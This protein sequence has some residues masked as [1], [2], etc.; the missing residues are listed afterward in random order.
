MTSQKTALVIGA[1]GIIGNHI[2]RELLTQGYEV[3]A[4]SRGVTSSQNL[5][6]LEVKSVQ[7]DLNDADSLKKAFQGIDYVFQAGAYY[8]R[9][10]FHKNL[11]DH[12]ALAQVENLIQ[13]LKESD[14]QKLVYTSSLTTIGQV[15][16][17][18]LADETHS[19][20]LTS[21]DPHPYFSL[22]HLCEERLRKAV[23]EEGVPIVIVN[24]TGVFG[25]YE[26]KPKSLCLVPQL[27]ERSLPAYVD[28][29][30]NVVSASD[31]AKGQILAAVQGREGERYILGSENTMVATVIHE[32]CAAAGVKP[33]FLKLPVKLAL[34]PSI[35]S[36]V[37][38]Y[39]TGT[40]PVM[41]SLGLRFVQYGQHFSIEKAKKEL[42]FQPTEMKP[43]YAEAIAWFRQI[44][45]C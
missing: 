19:Y 22:K 2:V 6:N 35:M 17:G 42:G 20:N 29:L 32:I 44:G 14:V 12:V 7:L 34:F 11:H 8:P 5:K 45:Y 23:A 36:E 31:V 21:K 9:S 16:K 28:G 26:L 24:P 40:M 18:E 4:G 27:V 25:A 30:M 13:V 43:A 10:M 15:K 1:T 39:L 41:S 37:W 38:A 3:T 33:P